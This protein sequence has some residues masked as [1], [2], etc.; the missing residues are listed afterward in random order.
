MIA[1]EN[2]A[3]VYCI[4]AMVAHYAMVPFGWR[5]LRGSR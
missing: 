4:T 5:I 2:R 1:V 3:C